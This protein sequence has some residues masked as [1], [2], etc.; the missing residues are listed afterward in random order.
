MNL[1]TDTGFSMLLGK[2]NIQVCELIRNTWDGF[3][4]RIWGLPK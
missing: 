2:I 1:I 4:T 3:A